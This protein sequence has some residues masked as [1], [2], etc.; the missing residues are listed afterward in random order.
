VHLVANSLVVCFL[1]GP[2]LSQLQPTPTLAAAIT[3]SSPA[4]DA[5]Q[6]T[7]PEREPLAAGPVPEPSAL[8]LVGTALVGLALT[9]RRAHRRSR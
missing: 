4:S 7:P 5:A 1:L 2:C 9:V 6:A 3:V 8:F